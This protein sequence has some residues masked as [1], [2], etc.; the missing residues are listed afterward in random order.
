MKFFFSLT[1][2]A[3]LMFNTADAQQL[4][5]GKKHVN[6]GIK[7]GLNLYNVNNDNGVK[8]DAKAGINLGLLG[9][10]H[11]SQ[12]WAFQPELVYSDQG[13]K[14]IVEGVP[15]RLKLG[16]INVPLLVQYMFE[17]GFR[18]QAG[19]QV[20]F[21]INAKS[22]A[23][24]ITTDQKRF[25]KSVDFGLGAGVGYVDVKSG[26]GVDIR[27]NLGLSDINKNNT[28]KSTNMGLQVGAFYLFNNKN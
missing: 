7:A 13:A 17:N 11:L 25:Y 18:L 27:Y 14:H 4:H 6:V 10:I 12:Q 21:N 16:Y 1:L 3:I 15:S 23:N 9:H 28:F 8:Y 2:A 26:F 5:I 20:G 22:E 19:P 24:K